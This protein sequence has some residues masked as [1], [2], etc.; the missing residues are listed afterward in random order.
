LLINRSDKSNQFSLEALEPRLLLSG[1]GIG[2]V[3]T[4][5]MG[6]GDDVIS[7]IQVE[8]DMEVLST[9]IDDLDG[10][11]DV[12]DSAL[13]ASEND[14][15]DHAERSIS[16]SS[17]EEETLASEEESAAE[18]A[19]LIEEFALASEAPTNFKSTS[20]EGQEDLLSKR[21]VTTLTAANGPPAAGDA[22]FQ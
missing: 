14:A 4:G 12:E 6:D 3:A 19:L 17:A 11:F 9:E 7:A 13:S 10:L 22:L 16:A 20:L 15:E 1:D 2:V 5:F 18:P 21:L 8:H